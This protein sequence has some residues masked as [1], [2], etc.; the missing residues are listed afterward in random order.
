ML[1]SCDWLF[2]MHWV[3]NNS[4]ER[5][6]LGQRTKCHQARAKMV[7]PDGDSMDVNM[8]T[9]VLSKVGVPSWKHWLCHTD[10]N[11]G[12]RSTVIGCQWCSSISKWSVKS[13]SQTVSFIMKV[14]R[15]IHPHWEHDLSPSHLAELVGLL[16][17]VPLTDANLNMLSQ[18]SFC[19]DTSVQLMQGL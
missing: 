18:G 1:M 13:Q 3:C 4:S 12:F 16:R 17:T 19:I 10:V 11:M 7:S 9:E 5:A 6:W 15:F 2:C 14:S 8:L